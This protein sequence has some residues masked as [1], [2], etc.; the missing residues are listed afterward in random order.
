MAHVAEGSPVTF[1][2]ALPAYTRMQ[3]HIARVG[4]EHIW[5]SNGWK[6]SRE[7]LKVDRG[8]CM[9]PGRITF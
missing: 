7:T 2:P 1:H 5:L 8:R 6:V 9:S 3:V 4:D